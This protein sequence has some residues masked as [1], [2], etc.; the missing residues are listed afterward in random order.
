[1][2]LLGL[3][4]KLSSAVN[5]ALLARDISPDYHAFYANAFTENTSTANERGVYM[6]LELF[7][8]KYWKFSMFFDRFSFPWLRMNTT[9]PSTGNEIFLQSEYT[10]DENFSLYFRYENQIKETKIEDFI[11]QKKVNQSN[12]TSSYRFQISW[13]ITEHLRLKNRIEMSAYKSENQEGEVG[14]LFYQDVKYIFRRLP[15]ECNFRYAVFDTDSYNSRIYMFENDV[16]YGFS[17]PGF[18]GKGTRFYLNM[19]FTVGKYSDFW[20]KYEVSNY[21]NRQTIGTGNESV[22]GA[23][24][25]QIKIQYRLRF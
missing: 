5:L 4:T 8:A 19:K 20:F 17:V 15:F 24:L 22:E 21:S 16:L 14:L 18:Y 2:G 25:S 13:Y 10:L 7:P 9:K 11:Q 23:Q 1:M 12:S 3:N 6:G